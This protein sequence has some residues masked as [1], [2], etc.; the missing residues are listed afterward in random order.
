MAWHLALK[1]VEGSWLRVEPKVGVG[2]R[3][4]HQLFSNLNYDLFEKGSFVV[5]CCSKQNVSRGAEA[6]GLL[7][8]RECHRPVAAQ[9]GRDARYAASAIMSSKDRCSTVGFISTL[10][11]PA[12]APCL[13]S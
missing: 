9:G 4:G 7:L 8:L 2:G 11:L 12:R 3:A 10:P 5:P 6:P 1:A 13:K